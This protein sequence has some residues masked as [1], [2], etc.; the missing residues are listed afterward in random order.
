MFVM[1]KVDMHTHTHYSY[2]DGLDSPKAMIRAAE[3]FGLSGI[4]IT[5]HDNMDG[6]EEALAVKSSIHI[7]KGC[8]I[9]SK[10]GH[11]LAYGID[12]PISR[13]LPASRTI[14]LIHK[15]GG[16][17]AA[18]HPLDRFRKGIGEL[19]F[20]LPFDAVEARNGHNIYSNGKTEALC[21]KRNVPMVAGSDA[22]MAKEVGS[23]YT[24]FSDIGNFKDEII[25]NRTVVK[26]HSVSPKDIMEKWARTHILR[27]GMR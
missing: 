4:A 18:A 27:Q 8:E 17:A 26:G 13:G 1:L 11:I 2:C 9:S 16:I 21:K 6:I 12:E 22:H 20:S 19:A 7:I 25:S 14:E 24:L 5:D 3:A 23:C 15:Q 10:E